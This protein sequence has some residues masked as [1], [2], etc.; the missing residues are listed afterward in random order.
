M[1]VSGYSSLM[2]LQLR[3]SRGIGSSR[4]G[5]KQ[6]ATEGLL[7]QVTW[8]HRLTGSRCDW[9]R[10]RATSPKYS[11]KQAQ[12]TVIN[13]GLSE[14][15]GMSGSMILMMQTVQIPGPFFLSRYSQGEIRV[16]PEMERS[17]DC[18]REGRKVVRAREGP[19][20]RGRHFSGSQSLM[21][22][23]KSEKSR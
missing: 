1:G 10:A 21:G 9:I 15:S 4:R 6:L 20:R 3:G 14:G 5:K 23:P 17:E 12:N 16:Q 7:L 11:V 18:Q 13:Q 2:R 22:S 19:V 8:G